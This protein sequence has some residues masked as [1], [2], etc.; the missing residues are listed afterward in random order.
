[1]ISILIQ[2]I[3]NFVKFFERSTNV[4]HIINSNK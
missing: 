2:P 4:N 3:L 1:M